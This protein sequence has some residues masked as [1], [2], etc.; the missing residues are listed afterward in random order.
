MSAQ[1]LALV[2]AFLRCRLSVLLFSVPE[3]GRW[4]FKTFASAKLQLFSDMCK[5]LCKNHSKIMAFLTQISL[6]ST[7]FPAGFNGCSMDAERVLNGCM[8][9]PEHPFI[10]LL[11]R[12]LFYRSPLFQRQTHMMSHEIAKSSLNRLIIFPCFPLCLIILSLPYSP[13]F[14]V[15]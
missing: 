5:Y 11:F 10:T 8:S 12:S 1:R 7:W 4:S 9:Q 13:P 6:L 3:I 14:R 15:M 2:S